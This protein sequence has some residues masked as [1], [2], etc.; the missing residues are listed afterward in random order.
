MKKPSALDWPPLTNKGRLF[1]DFYLRQNQSRMAAAPCRRSKVQRPRVPSL[2]QRERESMGALIQ[3]TVLLG[4][5]RLALSAQLNRFFCF[6][7]QWFRLCFGP[8]DLRTRSSDRGFTPVS[9]MQLLSYAHQICPWYD[10]T[11]EQSYSE[12]ADEVW[13]SDE[14]SF[15]LSTEN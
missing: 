7:L 10:L 8:S 15:F 6:F 12:Q 9:K 3:N 13:H 11:D 1:P 2:E 14:F 5:N 4:L